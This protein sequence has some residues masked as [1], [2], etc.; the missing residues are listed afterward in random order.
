MIRDKLY[1]Q[2]IIDYTKN[3][4]INTF[5]NEEGKEINVLMKEIIINNCNPLERR[6][7]NYK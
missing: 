1:K 2:R 4:K 5:F 6:K 7:L 3:I